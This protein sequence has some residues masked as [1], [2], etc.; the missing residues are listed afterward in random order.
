MLG[1]IAGHNLSVKQRMMTLGA[2]AVVG[3]ASMLGAGWYQNSRADAA[4]E[5]AIESQIAMERVGEMRLA[6]SNLVLA[7]MDTIIDRD[8]RV[9]QPERLAIMAESGAMLSDN[10][11]TLTSVAADAG[12]PALIDGYAEKV[13]ALRK[14]I[15]VDLKALVEAGAEPG[16]YA[17]A[18]DI[19]DS[20]GDEVAEMLTKI[21]G[22]GG[23]L[24]EQRVSEAQ[25][26]SAEALYIQLVLGCIAFVSVLAL[27]LIHGNAI[28]NGIQ[29]VRA[30]LQSI[31]DGNY[32][33]DVAEKARKDEIGDIA[34]SADLFRLAAIE[35]IQMEAEAEKEREERERE[36][37]S[38]AAAT[39]EDARVIKSAVDQLGQGINMLAEGDL[40]PT[41]SSAFA[42]ELD[43]LR[44]DF[45]Q[46]TERLRNVMRDIATS[47]ASI[48]ANSHQMRSAADDLARRTEQQAASL[49]ETSASL[50]QITATVRTAAERAEE[51][52]RMV[53]GAKDFAERSS[54]VVGDAVAAME[55]IQTATGEIG[56]IIN[57]I[58][59]I[60]FQTN[61]LA[62]N[63]GVEAARAGDAGK[64][65]AVVAQEVRALAG[66]AADAARDI[67]DLVG[68]SNDEVKTGVDLVAAAGE[69]LHRIGEEV[70]QINDHVKSIVTA[71]REQSAGLSEINV[72]VGQMDQVTQKNAAMVEET[73][74]A[75][76]TLAQDAE[77]LTRLVG[78]FKT[79]GNAASAP[80][81]PAAATAAAVPKAS[82]ARDLMNRVAGSINR[83]A[84][85]GRAGTAAATETWEEF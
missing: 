54:V 6:V 35:K 64:G 23:R 41:I 19:I 31:I 14:A 17:A 8:E 7:A 46:L 13:A 45:N 21:A 32:Q 59:E 4:L 29:S 18:D 22:L 73:N 2:A 50:D 9:V 39:E 67:K 72:A 60:A 47:T 66:R 16:S 51:A 49:E 81:K 56:K 52:S 37:L 26:S 20:S 76:H 53:D 70:L 63:A 80:V 43:R 40:S 58:D 27:Q 61:L 44:S 71:A 10:V 55:R 12:Q 25:E 65:F 84:P 83:S 69:A 33:A 79:G 42:G 57:V 34:R 5:R 78:Q 74:A 68:K 62:L 11:E 36:R 75:S 30:F 28:V 48:T 24:I 15:E 82:P 77:N 85:A 3:I 38:R 1:F